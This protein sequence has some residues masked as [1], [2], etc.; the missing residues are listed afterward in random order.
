QGG[1]ADTTGAIAGMLAGAYYGVE[2]IPRR[3]MRKLDRRL[4]G[5][6]VSLSRQLVRLAGSRPTA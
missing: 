1:D 3:W 5:E 6:I 2:G 4:L